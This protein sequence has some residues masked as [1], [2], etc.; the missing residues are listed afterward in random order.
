[1]TNRT[2]QG[3]RI[4]GGHST[5]IEG[6]DKFL[7]QLEEWPEVRTTHARSF[8]RSRKSSRA[9]G[10]NFRATRWEVVGD[11][12]VGIRCIATAGTANQIVVLTSNDLE[13]LK[14]RLQQEGWCDSFH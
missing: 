6:L 8:T 2:R 7:R 5:L 9:G 10:L 14:S 11:K 1:M 3:K 4:T 12:R 13:K